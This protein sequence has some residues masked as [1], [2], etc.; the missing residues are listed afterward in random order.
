MGN[1]SL[2]LFAFLIALPAILLAVVLFWVAS[3][4]ASTFV[5]VAAIGLALG[6]IIVAVATGTALDAIFKG[7][8]Y[9]YVTD[10]TLPAELDTQEFGNAF[11]AAPA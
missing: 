7:V 10:R 9:A 2:G 1:F 11:A 3:A 5:A 6:L 8:M 4:V